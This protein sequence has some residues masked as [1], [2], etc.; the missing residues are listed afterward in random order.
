MDFNLLLENTNF[1]EKHFKELKKIRSLISKSDIILI[2]RELKTFVDMKFPEYR[3]LLED[4]QISNLLFAKTIEN[5]YES[6]FSKKSLNLMVNS[7]L[8]IHKKWDINFV[9]FIQV[10]SVFVG[11]FLNLIF[12]K[13]NKEEW[14]LFKTV[15]KLL[16]TIGEY[17]L[18]A[19][20]TEIE[21]I[22]K[23]PITGLLPRYKI[24]QFF[25]NLKEANKNCYGFVLDIRSFANINT[26]L[27]YEAGD[28]VLIHISNILKNKLKIKDNTN[29][30]R[31]QGDQFFI[32]IESSSQEEALEL[33]ENSLESI[34][35]NP[36]TLPISGKLQPINLSLISVGS[37]VLNSCN[38]SCFMW[39]IE[40]ALSEYKKIKKS[41]V[42]ILDEKVKNQCRIQRKNIQR[43]ISAVE[44]NRIAFAIQKIIDISTGNLF[45]YEALARLISVN[46]EIIPA[47]L[48]FKGLNLYSLDEE[49]DKIVIDKSFKFKS[50]TEMRE[51]LSVNVSNTLLEGNTDFLIK[52]AQ[53]YKVNPN[54]V[55]VEL[56]ERQNLSLITNLPDKVNYLRKAGFKIFIDDFGVDYANFHL[57]EKIE[58]DGIKIDGKFIKGIG[59]N[60]IDRE[61]VNFV[62]SIGKE[63]GISVIAEFV[64]EKKILKILKEISGEI[65][66]LGQGYLFGKPEVKT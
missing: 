34:R 4:V 24:R 7:I 58:V 22:E 57:L 64:E 5:F 39:T 16:I 49:I 29:L 8:K 54:E 38:Y 55:I 23:D 63:L 46:G 40:N 11:K 32:F 15:S 48:F 25:E 36:I 18:I 19:K 31:L 6:F 9:D 17:F 44:N 21:I 42:F 20:R 3:K 2:G 1:S 62:L 14:Q 12:R 65:N 41:G 35:K 33:I 26:V 30:F 45:G 51:I 13:L 66:V 28:T 47:N 43:V 59:D 27:G 10:Y 52:T 60:T 53:K 61:F 37:E 50:A 56:T